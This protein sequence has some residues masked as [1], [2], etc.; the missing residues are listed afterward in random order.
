MITDDNEARR[1]R[2]EGG[3]RGGGLTSLSC[4]RLVKK[5]LDIIT[6]TSGDVP[7]RFLPVGRRWGWVLLGCKIANENVE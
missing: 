2:E 6:I 4:K 3:G 1:R 7:S 5:M